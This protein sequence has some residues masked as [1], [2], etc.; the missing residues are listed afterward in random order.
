VS[1]PAGFVPW[2]N[3]RGI[4][5]YHTASWGT[6]DHAAFRAWKRDRMR[7]RWNAY[8]L[9]GFPA[10]LGDRLRDRMRAD[11]QAAEAPAPSRPYRAC[12]CHPGTPVASLRDRRAPEETVA[13]RDVETWTAREFHRSGLRPRV[14]AAL[15]YLAVNFG[16]HA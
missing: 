2:A 14:A 9:A 6:E 13:P 5:P 4:S 1:I 15:A 8:H 11:V 7:R 3:A 12:P 16:A 10:L